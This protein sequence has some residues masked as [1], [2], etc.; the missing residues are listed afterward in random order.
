MDLHNY[1]FLARKEPGS[2]KPDKT[3]DEEKFTSL[4]MSLARTS[5]IT[6]DRNTPKTNAKQLDYKIEIVKKSVL[7]DTNGIELNK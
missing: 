2:E 1:V 3:L 6:Q 4:S 5:W 7:F